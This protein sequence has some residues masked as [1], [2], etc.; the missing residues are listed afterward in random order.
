MGSLEEPYDPNVAPRFVAWPPPEMTNVPRRFHGIEHPNPLDD[1]PEE[2]RDITVTGYPVSLQLQKEF[3]G[4]VA[5][6]AISMFKVKKRGKIPALNA[7]M[8]G[9]AEY[10]AWTERRDEPVP[11]WNHTTT[12]QLLARMELR[13]VVFAIPKDVLDDRTTYQVEVMIEREQKLYFIWEFTTGSQLE[14]LK[15]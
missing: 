9:Q 10:R 11:T 4:G 13:D 5:G 2:Y 15:F 14:G 3:A 1:Q 12:D 8:Q 6:S 7:V